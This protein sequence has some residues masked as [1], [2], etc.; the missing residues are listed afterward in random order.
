MKN[1][2]IS[3]KRVLSVFVAALMLAALAPSA[4]AAS[5]ITTATAS[6]MNDTVT[7]SGE[8][9]GAADTLHVLAFMT[10]TGD[11]PSYS[12]PDKILAVAYGTNKDSASAFKLEMLVPDSVPTGTYAITLGAS[13]SSATYRLTF[14]YTGYADRT[15]VLEAFYGENITAEGLISVL[16]SVSGILNAAGSSESIYK[17]LGDKG[18]LKYAELILS[19][20]D[21]VSEDNKTIEEFGVLSNEALVVA[22]VLTASSDSEYENASK[23]IGEYA[24]VIGLDTADENYTMITEPQNLVKSILTANPEMTCADDVKDALKTAL[25]IARLNETAYL[26]YPNYIKENLKFFGVTSSEL[27]SMTSTTKKTEYLC[28]AIRSR[29]P[30][31]SVD[32]FADLWEDA[33]EE[34]TKNYNSYTSSNSGGSGGGSSGSSSKKTSGSTL[35]VAPS[36]LK[37]DPLDKR[38]LV[39]E[40]YN[41]IDDY[42]WAF[43][44]ILALTE[45]GIISGTGE[46]KFEPSRALKR[47]EFMKLLVN[48]F[49][50]ADLT[51]TSSFTDVTDTD[52]WYYVYIASAE[53]AGITSG[54]G[55]GT[56]GIGDEVTREEMAALIYRA[57]VKAGKPVSSNTVVSYK[58][59]AMISDYAVGAVASL[60]ASGVI[61]GSNGMFSPKNSATRAE[62]AVVINNIKNLI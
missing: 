39:T 16:D 21:R 37:D 17:A 34:A 15:A 54:R 50:L 23:A 24:D 56:F 30:I 12:N 36:L 14:E 44:A 58:D 20:R 25:Y 48:T 40:Y 29:L 7:I 41:D 38:L 18:K 45:D 59:A 3:M 51:A 33:C 61:S 11:T 43:T 47:E 4:F 46:N 53:S 22:A 8:L 6:V 42:E 31:Y 9:S 52:A 28:K 5:K 60:T 49:G 10:K 19:Y 26:A 13:D 62:A 57:A 27:S 35:T 55:D 32:E 1:K 2:T